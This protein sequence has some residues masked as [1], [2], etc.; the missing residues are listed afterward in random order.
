MGVPQNFKVDG[1]L[2]QKNSSFF[3]NKINDDTLI[4]QL[5]NKNFKTKFAVIPLKNSNEYIVFIELSN[6][7]LYDIVKELKGTPLGILGNLPSI[8]LLLHRSK[9]IILVWRVLFHQLI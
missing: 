4:Y 8:I 7:S 3:L 2:M 1:L 5:N 9:L 6:I